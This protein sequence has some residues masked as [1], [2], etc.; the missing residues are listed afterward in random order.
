MKNMKRSILF[1]GPLPKYEVS[2]QSAHAVVT[3]LKRDRHEPL[4]IGITWYGN[5]F[6]HDGP[7]A[8]IADNTW[9]AEW[10]NLNESMRFKDRVGPFVLLRWQQPHMEGGFGWE[11]MA[12]P[13]K[14]AA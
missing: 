5:W 1:G 3:H 8:R 10:C 7:V 12:T 11:A 6:R 14:P 4:L 2:L 9:L 13:Y